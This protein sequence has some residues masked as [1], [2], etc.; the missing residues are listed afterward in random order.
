VEAHTRNA[1]I[2]AKAANAICEPTKIGDRLDNAAKI[3]KA[4]FTAAKITF[5]V[6]RD[7]LI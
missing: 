3:A 5:N 7:G 4:V 1:T 6:I 2:K